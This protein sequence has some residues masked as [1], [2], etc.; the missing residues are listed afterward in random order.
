MMSFDSVVMTHV[1]LKQQVPQRNRAILNYAVDTVLRPTGAKSGGLL[2]FITLKKREVVRH[3]YT[4]HFC[5]RR[6]V[7]NM[8][9]TSLAWHRDRYECDTGHGGHYC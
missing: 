4:I 6:I 8:R 1:P 2:L 3:T 9:S 5:R 7:R